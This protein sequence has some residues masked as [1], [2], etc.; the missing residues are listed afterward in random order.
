MAIAINGAGTITGITAGGLPDASVVAADILDA[1]VTTAKVADNAITLAK[2]AGN[3]DG[4]IITFDA[5]GDPVAVGPGTDGQVLTS[6]G[7][8]SPPAFEAA[9]GGSNGWNFISEIVASNDA[10]IEI[11]SGWTGGYDKYM[12]AIS[13]LDPVDDDEELRMVVSTDGGSSYHE[14]SS[15]YRQGASCYGTGSAR[16]D[17]ASNTLAYL[18]ILGGTASTNSVGS[19]ENRPANVFITLDSPEKTSTVTVI[20]WNGGHHTAGNEAQTVNGIGWYNVGSEDLNAVEFQFEAG[21]VNRGNFALYG[22]KNS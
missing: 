11:T 19:Q 1:N 15:N 22:L 2:M 14:S 8:G 5:S 7:A 3:T 9:G 4:K 13:D 16:D 12:I 20:C 18:R 17:F 21:N 10:T 6:T